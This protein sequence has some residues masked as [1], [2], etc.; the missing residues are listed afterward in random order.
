MSAARRGSALVLDAV[1]L[2]AGAGSRLGGQ[3]KSLLERDGVPLIRHQIAALRAAG[4]RELVVV[5]GH[6]AEPIA[7]ALAGV[8]V[9]Q[10]RN[11]APDQGQASS[12]RV[13]LQALRDGLDGVV[14]ALADQPLIDKADVAALIAAF[15]CRADAAMVVPRVAGA[16]GNPV[17]ITA[18]LRAEW[19]AG[20]AAEV[21][22]RWR[23][24]HPGRVAWFDRDNDHYR[25]DIDTVEDIEQF[26]R[27]TGQ[28]LHWPR[29]G[30]R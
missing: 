13:G 29:L 14:V 28:P 6:H 8:A 12:L 21:G 11:A 26:T 18:E 4:M 10:V 16:P 25:L 24:A 7:A 17:L 30:S 19:L 3:P 5:L 9:T 23:D 1:L 22:R 20:P 27:S 2:A 15:E